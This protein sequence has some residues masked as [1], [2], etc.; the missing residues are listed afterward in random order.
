MDGCVFETVMLLDLMC[1]QMIPMSMDLVHIAASTTASI[2]DNSFVT[3]SEN[4][5]YQTKTLCKQLR[6]LVEM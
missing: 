1:P 2:N 4:I 5:K 6:T 3:S